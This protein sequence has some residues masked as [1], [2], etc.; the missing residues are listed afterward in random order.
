MKPNI[1]DWKY[2]YKFDENGNYP[3]TAV[4]ILSE[5][6]LNKKEALEILRKEQDGYKPSNYKSFTPVAGISHWSVVGWSGRFETILYANI[7]AYNEQ[8]GKPFWN[9]PTHKD[10]KRFKRDEFIFKR[11]LK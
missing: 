6:R 9:E 3:L 1:Y 10:F 11:N 4:V 5:Y 8:K 7:D 2:G